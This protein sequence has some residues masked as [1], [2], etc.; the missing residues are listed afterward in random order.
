MILSLFCSLL[1]FFVISVIHVPVIF[2]SFNILDVQLY[3][4]GT[5]PIPKRN[6][7]RRYERQFPP[8][9]EYLTL[10][11]MVMFTIF[12]G[13]MKYRHLP[14]LFASM[15]YNPLVDF[16]LVNVIENDNDVT[17]LSDLKAQMN[18]HNLYIHKQTMQEFR[19]VIN[20]KLGLDISFNKSWYYK[21]NDYK[22]VIAYLYPEYVNSYHRYWGYCDFD[23]I[24]GNFSSFSYLFQNSDFVIIGNS[25]YLFYAIRF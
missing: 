18:V 21:M 11:R 14:L 8:G 17:R 1:L 3:A 12:M 6:Y 5:L 25:I 23:L 20:N 24:W 22:P 15:K 13:E 4:N 10:P 2:S 16:V 9:S 19:D 7:Q